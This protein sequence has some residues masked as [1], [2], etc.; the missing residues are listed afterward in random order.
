MQDIPLANANLLWN[1]GF[2]GEEPAFVVR[3]LGHRDYDRYD[4]QVGAC[5]DKW[6]RL[7][8]EPE[9]LLL[10]A[11]VEAWHIAAFYKVPIEMVH[12]GMLVIPEYRATLAQDC[13]PTKYQ[14]E[15][16]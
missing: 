2:D 3:P 14:H 6:Q 8:V 5:T 12:E 1:S 7:A 15:R 16:A 10:L 4:Y 13:L 9:K 11:M